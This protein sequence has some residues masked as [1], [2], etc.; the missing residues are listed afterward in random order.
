MIEEGYAHMSKLNGYLLVYHVTFKKRKSQSIICF[1][2]H[3]SWPLESW[4]IS[5]LKHSFQT[6]SVCES[7]SMRSC[8][9]I[10]TSIPE[11]TRFP[12]AIGSSNSI[13]QTVHST[14]WWSRNWKSRKIFC[15]IKTYSTWQSFLRVMEILLVW[16]SSSP[17]HFWIPGVRLI[18]CFQWY[19][20]S[21][22]MKIRDPG[23]R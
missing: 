17:S 5:F 19:R 9:A 6:G 16:V 21:P 2:K 11:T 7:G 23:V 1:H 22:D 13:Q 8:S 10:W 12:S 4:I 15:W 20:A 3:S 14:T 18:S